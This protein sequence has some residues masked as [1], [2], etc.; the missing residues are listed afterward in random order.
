MDDKFLSYSNH[1][2][3]RD[4]SNFDGTIQNLYTAD[5]GSLTP[6]FVKPVLADDTFKISLNSE[7]KVNTLSAPAYSNIKQNFYSFFVANQSVWSHWNDFISNGSDF[8]NVYGSNIT[9][10]DLK[11]VWKIPSIQTNHLQ[12]ISKL[13][14]G[15]AIPILSVTADEYDL[16][17]SSNLNILRV[18]PY[19]SIDP[20]S[21]NTLQP[22]INEFIY[23]FSGFHTLKGDPSVPV[24]VDDSFIN[25]LFYVF[26]KDWRYVQKLCPYIHFQNAKLRYSGGVYNITFTQIDFGCSIDDM[27]YL[28]SLLYGND[29]F[30]NPTF[31]PS[32]DYQAA[33]HPQFMRFRSFCDESSTSVDVNDSPFGFRANVFNFAANSINLNST[34]MYRKSVGTA[35]YVDFTP[36]I[37]FANANGVSQEIL[38]AKYVKLSSFWHK[39]LITVKTSGSQGADGDYVL[40]Y[41]NDDVVLKSL[42][43][44]SSEYI[45]LFE[46]DDFY[47]ILKPMS[48]CMMSN[49]QITDPTLVSD[50][51]YT[52]FDDSLSGSLPYV[53]VTNPSAAYNQNLIDSSAF[54]PRC[55]VSL[56][57]YCTDNEILVPQLIGLYKVFQMFENPKLSHV[58]TFIP[59][60]DS[61]AIANGM[62]TF[63]FMLYLANSAVKTLDYNNIPYEGFTV[64][65]YWSYFGEHIN[66]LPFMS[67]SKIFDEYF[68]NRTVSSPELDYCQVNSSA[69]YLYNNYYTIA[70]YRIPNNHYIDYDDE[71][72]QN[73]WVIPFDVLP[74]NGVGTF[75]LNQI[76]QGYDIPVAIQGDNEFHYFNVTCFA[77]LFS[78]LTGFQLNHCVNHQVIK[79]YT[80]LFTDTD[81][82]YLD[83][84]Y[85]AIINRF[86]LPNYYNGLLHFKYQNFNKD[87]F[88]SALLD[89]M[90][91]ANQEEIPDNVTE[92][93]TAEAKQSFWE[94]TAV[95]R[96]FKKFAQK[97]FG[98][99]PSHMERNR[100][101]LLGQAHSKISI[102]EIIQTSGTA[103]TPQG[104]RTGIAGGHSV[105]G[106]CKHNFNEQ[107][108]LIILSSITID[109]QYYQGLNRNLTPYDGFLDYPFANFYNI[110]NQSINMRE[111]NYTSNPSQ[112]LGLKSILGNSLRYRDLISLPPSRFTSVALNPVK[113]TQDN[114]QFDYNPNYCIDS[115]SD[116]DS[117]FGYVPRFSEWKCNFD[118]LHGDFR[119]TLMSWN[120]YRT[121]HTM[122]FLSHNFVNWELSGFNYD[123]NRLFAVTDNSD[124]FICSLFVNVEMKRPIPF[125]TIPKSA[126]N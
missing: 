2:T 105:N 23:F 35:E 80:G 115:D 112:R 8:Q 78:L 107:G 26:H 62:T 59:L 46:S 18:L 125:Y 108:Y 64:R 27:P 52:P 73:S 77:D 100:P 38:D 116:F 43:S 63:T 87:Y 42:V 70:N 106:I 58:L 89:A 40:W 56:P 25:N 91:G 30:E 51:K 28:I 68:R 90:S 72:Y 48:Y 66:A 4:F 123:L 15:F 36:D 82:K 47:P 104:T 33:I 37:D 85:G 61:S 83:V 45:A 16:N 119:N 12:F 81:T 74:K 126:V 22:N 98:T 14:K 50:V 32:I 93:R 10:Q 24:S 114:Y 97:M 53:H 122:P 13:A 102:G 69:L 31:N 88:S 94:Q 103:E 118:E 110:G 79:P 71:N 21:L 92:L 75:N 117:V 121:L 1:S 7:V 29:I 39:E 34:S 101:L 49:N 84:L 96:S 9:N 65:D 44:N 95:A 76:V 6:V 54:I 109:S 124:K 60:F 11:S 3:N 86:Y 5:F 20:T 57:F 120:T 67:E 111:L 99:T 19:H 113:V 17:I 55:D 41:V